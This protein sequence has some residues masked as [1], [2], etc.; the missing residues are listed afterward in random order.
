MVIIEWMSQIRIL[1]FLIENYKYHL[2]WYLF[3]QNLC[4]IEIN[5]F[6]NKPYSG[7]IFLTC[8]WTIAWSKKQPP[9]EHD[10]QHVGCPLQEDACSKCWWSQHTQEWKQENS[11][12]KIDIKKIKFQILRYIPVFI[13]IGCQK[14]EGK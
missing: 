5:N 14:H 12:W 3:N 1:V 10:G 9:Q 13:V 6:G 7:W 4:F 8:E 11:H 2:L